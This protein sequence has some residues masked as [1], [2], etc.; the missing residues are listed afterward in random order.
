MPFKPTNSLY[1]YYILICEELN[2]NVGQSVFVLEVNKNLPVKTEAVEINHKLLLIISSYL[3]FSHDVSDITALMHDH[4]IL[5]IQT[6]VDICT[7]W[8]PIS[9]K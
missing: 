8:M 6:A 3:Q 4:F 1:I 9:Y 7:P 5:A 2:I